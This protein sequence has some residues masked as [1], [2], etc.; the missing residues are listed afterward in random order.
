M[1]TAI[2]LLIVVLILHLAEEVRT[3]FREQF[4]TGAM[5]R[6]VLI[7]INVVLY[8]FCFATLLL[9]ARG[10]TIAVPMAWIFAAAMTLNGIGHLGIMVLKRRY[11]PGGLTAPLLL[12]ASAYL[13]NTLPPVV[14]SALFPGNN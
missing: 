6:P 8:T 11:F 4:I 1:T 12:L 10:A 7:G 14:T 2:L 5:P 9:A 13:A 3:G